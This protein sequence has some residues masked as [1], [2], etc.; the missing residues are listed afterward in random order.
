MKTKFEILLFVIVVFMLNS[1]ST[2]EPPLPPEEEP[3]KAIK[4]KML[5]VSC[6]EAFISISA[7]DTV[8]PVNITLKKDDAAMFSFIL[9]QTDTTVIDTTLQPDITY[10]YQTTALIKGKEENSDTLQ[11]KTLPTT[12]HNFTWQ[13]FDFG[14]PNYGSSVLNDVAIIDENNIWAVGEIYADTTG[15]A[16]NAVH[17]NGGI[18]ELKKIYFPTV[19]GSTDL[20]PYP[21]K[22]I[23]A[24]DNGEIWIS[25]SGDKIAIL[26][27]GIQIDKF[28]LPSNVSMS[29]NKIWGSSSNDLYIV[30]N[31]GNI[32]HYQ[33]GSWSK[34]ESGTTTNI[35]DIWGY[36]DPSNNYKT[37]L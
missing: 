9:T 11:V 20:T 14:N 4:L 13:T 16:Y 12:S 1:C 27:N 21:A 23:F 8:L 36:Y 2:T 37:V 3:P 34:I 26:E 30:G 7:G 15:Q 33:N 6:T 22:A 18:W 28:C 10:V 29:I 19:C 5:E 24:F 35:N 32:A 17:W 25:S 31:G